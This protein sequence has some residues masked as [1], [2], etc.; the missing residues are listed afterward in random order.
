MLGLNGGVN[1]TGA[2]A[3]QLTQANLTNAGQLS[4]AYTGNQNALQQQQQLLQAIQGQNGLGNQS[5]VYG[6][7]QGIANGTGPNP[8]QAML[9]QATGQNVS[10]Q[11]AL[12]AGQRGAGANPALIAR[13]AAQQG[14]NL[15]QQAVGQGA[16]MQAQQSLNAIGAAGNLANQ[17]VSNQMGAVNANTTAQQAEQQAL[18][19][20]QQASNQQVTGFNQAQLTSGMSNQ[21]GQNLSAG[22][23]AIGQ[24][25]S[26]ISGGLAG[27]ALLA[28][29]GTVPQ[30]GYTSSYVQSLYHGGNVGNKLKAGGNVPGKPQHL[31]NDY[32][33]DTVKAMLSP[34]E[35]VIPN[36]VMQSKDPVRGAAAFV[37]AQLAKKRK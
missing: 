24:G 19:N 37:Q 32:R 16:S 34:G 11:A 15:Q 7:L 25:A 8:A 5:Q 26:G 2:Q 1:G 21:S 20:A 3:P 10:N 31:G 30:P 28:P 18:L 23:G 4:S 33:N 9:N 27:L 22:M 35:V 36:S 29:G 17:Q 13:Q 14:A 6:Q 12:M